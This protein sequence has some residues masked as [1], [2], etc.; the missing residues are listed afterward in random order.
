MVITQNAQG[1]QKR[2]PPE[3]TSL[4]L[5]YTLSQKQLHVY[6]STPGSGS[7]GLDYI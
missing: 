1:L 3:C 7:T 5:D 2:S 4:Y 6:A